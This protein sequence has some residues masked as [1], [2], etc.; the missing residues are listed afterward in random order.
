MKKKSARQRAIE[1][2]HRWYQKTFPEPEQQKK[3]GPA[4]LMDIDIR[5]RKILQQRRMIRQLSRRLAKQRR[6]A[7]LLRVQLNELERHVI[8]AHQCDMVCRLVKFIDPK[9]T[10]LFSALPKVASKDTF[11][12]W[13][14]DRVPDQHIGWWWRRP[15]QWI[16]NLFKKEK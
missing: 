13:V 14:I 1:E 4:W 9:D 7:T 15:Y 5:D 12:Q 3:R 8:D 11:H 6:E 10:P 2:E 16:L